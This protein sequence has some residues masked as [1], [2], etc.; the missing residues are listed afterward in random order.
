MNQLSPAEISALTTESKRFKYESINKIFNEELNQNFTAQEIIYKGLAFP[1]KNIKIKITGKR[2]YLLENPINAIPNDS[3]GIY[4]IWQ[5]TKLLIGKNV[6]MKAVY[7]GQGNVKARLNTHHSKKRLSSQFGSYFISFYEINLRLAL[8]F[9]KAFL[10]NY[11]FELNTEHMYGEEELYAL[12]DEEIVNYGNLKFIENVTKKNHNYQMLID[13]D[14]N[15]V[16]LEPI[17][18]SE[19]D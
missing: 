14:A 7:I 5:D 17:K 15:E 10:E 4:I 16:K 12:F 2:N 13:K 11:F 1:R 8:Y 19:I 18:C 6:L 9:E 3:L